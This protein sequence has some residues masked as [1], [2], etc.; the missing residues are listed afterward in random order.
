MTRP[1]RLTMDEA[2][3]G[4]LTLLEE[5]PELTIVEALRCVGRGAH[6]CRNWRYRDEAFRA[7][8]DLV[9]AARRRGLTPVAAIPPGLVA[10]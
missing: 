7:A 10:R 5:V 8:M 6:T 4:F 9:L 2:Q 1:I 3:A